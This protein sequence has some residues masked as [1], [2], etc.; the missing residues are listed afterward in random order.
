MIYFSHS[1][2]PNLLPQEWTDADAEPT[3]LVADQLSLQQTSWVGSKPGGVLELLFLDLDLSDFS[4][5][6]D[7]PPNF[8]SDSRFSSSLQSELKLFVEIEENLVLSVFFA[9]VTSYCV[10]GHSSPP[11]LHSPHHP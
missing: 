7:I 11:P 6:F 2:S 8:F 9:L 4:D 3:L 10:H 1:E 5:L